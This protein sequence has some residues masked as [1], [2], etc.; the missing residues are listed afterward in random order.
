MTV[1]LSIRPLQKDAAP[2][3]LFLCEQLLPNFNFLTFIIGITTAAAHRIEHAYSPPD[4]LKLNQGAH[5][6]LVQTGGLL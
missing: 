6:A 4:A 1:F 5:P 3:L 2:A